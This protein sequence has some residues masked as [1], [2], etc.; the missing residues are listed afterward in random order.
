MIL[1]GLPW[2]WTEIILSFLRLQVWEQSSF[3]FRNFKPSFL[4]SGL[5]VSFLTLLCSP[6]TMCWGLFAFQLVYLFSDVSS[7]LEQYASL[8][9]MPLKAY[10]SFM[11]NS[12][13]SASGEIYSNPPC[14]ND[15]L[16]SFYFH[17]VL[18]LMIG[19]QWS[20]MKFTQLCP[21]L[22]HPM[23][24]TLPGSSVRGILWV[25]ILKWVAISFSRGSS[26]PEIEPGS[27]ALQA[28]SLPSEPPGKPYIIWP[29]PAHII[30]SRLGHHP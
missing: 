1:N 7:S 5:F 25:R 17:R 13:L 15:A 30:H 8:P 12:N 6:T 21:T 14:E 16:L 20:E 29:S 11:S 9:R 19:A 27:P 2:K 4:H 28:D 23:D 10:S 3:S 26:W 24:Y 22:C 18:L